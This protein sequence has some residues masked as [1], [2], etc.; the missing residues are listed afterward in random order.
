MLGPHRLP[1]VLHQVPIFETMVA[2][3]RLRKSVFRNGLHAQG[4][5]PAGVGFAETAVA[6]GRIEGVTAAV[7]GGLERACIALCSQSVA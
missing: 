2:T 7:S 4:A 6:A 1:C 5:A 3:K